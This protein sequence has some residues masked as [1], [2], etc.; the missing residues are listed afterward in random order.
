MSLSKKILI[1]TGN[2]GK[3]REYED[4]LKN[5][6]IELISLADF[7]LVEPE[8][9]GKTFAENAFLK[10]RYYYT[11]TNLPAISD[12]SGL[13]IQSLD[14]LP[15]IY[16][17]RWAGDSKDFNLA[18]TKVYDS[19]VAKRV[20]PFKDKIPAFFYCAIV[21]KLTNDLEYL[22]TGKISGYIKFPAMGEHGF[23]YDPIFWPEG[24]NQCFAAMSKQEKN[25]ISHRK[26]A[27]SKLIEFLLKKY[28][29]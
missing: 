10:A 15:G 20:D 25:Q 1:A 11:K 9:T 19:L 23:G 17:A 3:I 16:S 22:F 21:L 27:V 24:Y 26:I 14:G 4:L 5:V 13:S 8:E 18:I 28:V 29:A 7:A 12:D 6:D 2:Q